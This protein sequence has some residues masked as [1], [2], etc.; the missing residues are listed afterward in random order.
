[1]K[2]ILSV[3]ILL[4]VAS[5]AFAL[6][7]ALVLRDDDRETT[8]NLYKVA[9]DDDSLL[10]VNERF[11]YSVM[12]P[13][14]AFTEVVVIPDNEDGM[15]LETKDGGGR[16]RVS[17]GFVMEDG[18]LKTSFE[19]ARRL[20]GEQNITNHE[21][22]ED[23]WE[24]YWWVGDVFHRRKLIASDDAW[25]DCEYS[26]TVDRTTGKEHPFDEISRLAIESL[27]MVEG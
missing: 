3:I 2:K 10:Y 8:A 14:K 17:G 5:C 22:G 24:L 27:T 15:I 21:V 20:V 18:Y 13:H 1:M 12:V 19:D 23:Y 6:D 25:C 7:P 26:L 4:F 9:G 16:F 11:G